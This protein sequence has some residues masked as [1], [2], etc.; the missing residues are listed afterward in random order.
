[1]ANVAI[2]AGDVS[3]GK[4]TSTRTLDPAKT[5]II[6]VLNKPLPFAGSKKQYVDKQN[7][8]S[9]SGYAEIVS[10]LKALPEKKPDLENIVID[11]IGYSMTSEFFARASE[12]GFKKFAEIGQHMQA[13]LAVAKDLPNNINVA[14][15]F[16]E[17]NVVS[18]GAIVSKNLKLIGRMLEDKYNPLGIVS[19]CLF[20]NVDYGDDG[21]PQYS[22]ITNRCKIE[23]ITIPAKTPM[24]MFDKL[25]VP[26][27]LKLVFDRMHEFYN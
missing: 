15:M 9:V 27:D 12:T 24:G 4:S 11:D 23:G 25:K 21:T 2:I 3:T 18:D 26:N 19:V 20:T 5:F 7:T 13:I 10:L 6:N 17:D 22:F 16:H 8:V 1:M 14:L